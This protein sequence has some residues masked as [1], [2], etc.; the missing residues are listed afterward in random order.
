MKFQIFALRVR[1]RTRWQP[2]RLVLVILLILVLIML[3]LYRQ[4]TEISLP[5][6]NGWIV[7]LP[8]SLLQET[9]SQG[10]PYISDQQQGLASRGS[11][12]FDDWWTRYAHAGTDP[13]AM[14]LLEMGWLAT[15]ERT[16][17]E[18]IMVPAN[19]TPTEPG[20]ADEPID[21]ADVDRFNGLETEPEDSASGKIGQG[22]L[23]EPLIALYNT[24]NAETY[25]PTDGKAKVEGENGGVAQVAQTLKQTLENEYGIPT[26]YVD[27]IHDYP[28]WSK[29]YVNSAKTVRALLEQ[30]PDLKILIDIHRDSLNLEDALTKKVNGQDTARI[31]FVVGSDQRMAHPN[32]RQNL[33]LAQKIADSLDS[34]YPGVCRGVRVQAGTYNQH[35]NSG[36]ILVEVG[37]DRNSLEEAKRAARLL[38]E[39]I[40]QVIKK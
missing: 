38:A 6:D 37:N 25:I 10:M 27:T 20:L 3:L 40:S 1:S 5:V 22:K 24:H 28:D 21:S 31:L 11:S 26:V 7:Q 33:A 39:A 36:V 12:R 23:G 30:Y 14:M 19:A 35:L 17:R 13:R 9:L 16:G 34:L 29:S 4:T 8:E 18:L 32:W 15:L 2:L